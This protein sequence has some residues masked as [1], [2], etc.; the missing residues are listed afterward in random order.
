[1]NVGSIK[2]SL[3]I[4]VIILSVFGVFAI[5]ALRAQQELLSQQALDYS[6]REQWDSAIACYSR[7][8]ERNANFYFDRGMC[9]LLNTQFNE[10]KS[11]FAVHTALHPKEADGWLMLAESALYIENFQLA[12]RASINFTKLEGKNSA[13]QFIHACA[14]FYQEKFFKSR[15]FFKV[16]SRL[17]PNAILPKTYLAMVFNKSFNGM[18]WPSCFVEINPDVNL[19]YPLN[20]YENEVYNWH[21][22][23]LI[24]NKFR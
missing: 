15:C 17:D 9:Y 12:Q 19:I 18:Q 3:T 20:A 16:A 10:A 8:P 13:A 4:K 23:H 1:M 5:G 14:L 11:D 22:N 6:Y 24:K 21:C 2:A 7:M